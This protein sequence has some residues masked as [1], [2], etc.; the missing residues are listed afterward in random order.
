[1]AATSANRAHS[2]A[3]SS[4]RS[5]LRTRRAV[6]RIAT[7]TSLAMGGTPPILA[8]GAPISKGVRNM[9]HA[10]LGLGLL[11]L[12]W[13]TARADDKKE[14]EALSG[15]WIITSVERDG[16]ADER[17]VDAVREHKDESYTITP[18][19]GPPITGTF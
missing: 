13:T 12:V 1:M 4:A 16:K 5:G 9:R 3:R 15:K 7:R 17:L 19:K 6:S 11:A 14:L 10:L 2:S 18:K 8:A